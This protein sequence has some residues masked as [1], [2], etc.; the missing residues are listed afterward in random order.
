MMDVLTNHMREIQSNYMREMQSEIRE[1]IKE[2]IQ[3]RE[4]RQQKDKIE[5]I[6]RDSEE[7][8]IHRRQL[9]IDKEDSN[10]KT[11][12]KD[13]YVETMKHAEI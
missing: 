5:L 9:E 3:E 2:T 10:K 12:I 7:K 4:A 1:I 8:E 6:A 11:H 13:L